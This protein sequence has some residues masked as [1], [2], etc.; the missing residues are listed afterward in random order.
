MT[1]AAMRYE[2]LGASGL[3]A[4]RLW[5]G[6]MMFGDQTGADE[7]GRI[8]ESACAAG[9]NAIDAA[10][11]YAA[12]ESERIVGRLI[13]ADRERWV[14]ATKAAD[15]TGEG[16]ND[17]ALSRRHLT[18]AVN[19]SLR[20]LNTDWIDVLYL[21]RDDE[22]TPVEET[23]TT[24]AGLIERGLIHYFGVSNFRAWRVA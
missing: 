5:L 23:A 22:T 24:L 16:P 10:D 8:V 7:A 21:H 14:V 3:R 2:P 4:S 19:A 13:V 18:L 12:G 1:H 11:S 20:R 6:T 17:R 15:P 9:I